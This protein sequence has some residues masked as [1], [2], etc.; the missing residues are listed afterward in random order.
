MMSNNTESATLEELFTTEFLSK[1]TNFSSFEEF[2]SQ[3]I[4]EKYPSMEDVP[5][6]EMDAFIVE[7]T[8]F[9][10]WLNMVGKARLDYYKNQLGF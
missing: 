1:Y 3:P 7:S 4:F 2:N 10:N 5:E 9:K 6:E 8:K